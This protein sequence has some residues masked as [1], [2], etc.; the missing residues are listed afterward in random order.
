MMES[1]KSRPFWR[2]RSA[3]SAATGTSRPIAFSS[4]TCVKTSRGVPSI[5]MSFEVVRGRK[6]P[7]GMTGTIASLY[8]YRDCY[9]RPV[10][11]YIVDSDG[12]RIAVGNCAFSV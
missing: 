5:G 10:R 1:G 6:F 9:G 3:S 12:N 8:T 4:L 7:V 11:D 2:S